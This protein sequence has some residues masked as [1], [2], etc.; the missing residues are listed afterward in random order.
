M[1]IV[2]AIP[3]DENLA[4]FIGKKGSSESITYYNRKFENDIIVAMF[5]SQDDEKVHALAESLLMASKIVLSTVNVDKK[6][7]EAFV[8]A[9]LLNKKLLLTDDNDVS[10]LLKGVHMSNYQIVPREGLLA[11]IISHD[12]PAQSRE[13]VRVDID[14]SFPVRGI[15]TVALGV[16]TRGVVRPHDKMCHSSGK[17][18]MVRSIQSQDEDVES[19]DVGTRVGLSLKD[20]GD[21]EMGKGDLLTSAPVRRSKKL[22]LDYKASPAAKETILESSTYRFVMNFA[23][24]DC[25]VTKVGP[26]ELELELA[27]AMPVE[28]GDEAFLVR[29]EMPRL[30]AS[31]KVKSA[32][33]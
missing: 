12:A 10:G 24:S 16:V 21:D 25:V 26:Q 31:G 27:S 28:V 33:A 3:V 13:G 1:N 5:P 23:R 4:S 22:V 6:F 11:S 29:Q 7:G 18:V 2:I 30:F 14:K 20:I 32:T 9:S 17:Q 8:A 19:A 15:G